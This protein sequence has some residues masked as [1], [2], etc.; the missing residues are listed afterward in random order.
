MTDDRQPRVLRRTYVGS[1][2][3]LPIVFSSQLL[4]RR[5][6]TSPKLHALGEAREDRRR[7]A[8]V[9]PRVF[10]PDHLRPPIRAWI[11]GV[12]PV[13]TNCTASTTTCPFVPSLETVTDPFFPASKRN[14]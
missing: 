1:C 14:T 13:G 8:R 5:C 12:A 2:D 3:Q 9:G 11:F 4:S 10:H 6:A 7:P